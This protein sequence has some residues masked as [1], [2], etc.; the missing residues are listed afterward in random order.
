MRELYYVYT[1]KLSPEYCGVFPLL[2]EVTFRRILVFYIS[3]KWAIILN[4][5]TCGDKRGLYQIYRYRPR[6]YKSVVLNTILFNSRSCLWCRG[7]QSNIIV[8]HHTCTAS[9]WIAPITKTKSNRSYISKVHT[10]VCKSLQ[11][12]I[13]L[14]P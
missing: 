9:Y 8:I 5:N 14:G 13:P 2:K 3:R 10:L 7:I 6:I 11:V 12:D 4:L 1:A